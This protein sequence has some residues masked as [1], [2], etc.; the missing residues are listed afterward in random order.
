MLSCR[1][2][3]IAFT[4]EEFRGQTFCRKVGLRVS[5]KSTT[6]GKQ[7]MEFVGTYGLVNFEGEQLRHNFVSMFYDILIATTLTKIIL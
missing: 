1:D 2:R 7:C 3:S 6:A 5:G 4:V